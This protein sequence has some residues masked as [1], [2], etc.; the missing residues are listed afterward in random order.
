[1]AEHGQVMSVDVKPD[2][3][4]DVKAGVRLE[5]GPPKVL[6]HVGEVPLFTRSYCIGKYGVIDNG[7]KFL[8]IEQPRALIDDGRMHVMTHWDA[9]I[10]H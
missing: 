6:F 3:K 4:L 8:A 9:A 7:Q 2:V 1:M 5:T 10:H